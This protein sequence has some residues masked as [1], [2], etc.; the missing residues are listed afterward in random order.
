LNSLETTKSVHMDPIHEICSF[1]KN[2]PKK[3]TCPRCNA[4]YCSLICFQSTDHIECAESFYQ[5]CVLENLSVSGNDDESKEKMMEVFKKLHE[6]DKLDCDN[7][8]LGD[9]NDELDSDDETESTNLEER[10]ANIDLDDTAEVWQ[11]LTP[12]ERQEFEAFLRSGDVSKFVP[13]WEPWWLQ[14]CNSKILDVDMIQSH[15]EKCPEVKEDIKEFSSI[16]KKIPSTCVKYN[17]VNIIAAYAFTVRYFN[18]DHFD[19]LEEAVGCI[20]SLSLCLSDN[21]IFEDSNS[22]IASVHEECT[23]NE[24]ITVDEENMNLMKEDAELILKGPWE[25][26]KKFYILCALSDLH[27]LVNSLLFKGKAKGTNCFLKLS[28]MYKLPK[29]KTLLCLKKL[30]YFLSYTVYYYE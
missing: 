14:Q 23:K 6:D 26:D 5:K 16:T 8:N 15:K 18:G 13:K 10:L 29:D 25:S 19:F 20:V 21:K 4:D 7:G 28:Q 27:N 12:D 2:T 9:D 11:K 24:W 1:C 3:Y 30:E 17:L 22:A